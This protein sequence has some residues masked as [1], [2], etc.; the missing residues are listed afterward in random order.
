MY[1]V[2]VTK[3]SSWKLKL[4]FILI[5]LQL[6]QKYIP[7]FGVWTLPEAAEV[8]EDAYYAENPLKKLLFSL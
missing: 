4:N 6:L 8:S 1:R 5:T 2:L 7:D 3:T